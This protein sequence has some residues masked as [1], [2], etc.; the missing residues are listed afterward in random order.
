MKT[1]AFSRQF[2]ILCVFTL[3][4]IYFSCFISHDTFVLELYSI[5]V[6]ISQSKLEKYE[7]KLILLYNRGKA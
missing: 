5:K 6:I 1:L 3:R 4:L 2:S 7:K